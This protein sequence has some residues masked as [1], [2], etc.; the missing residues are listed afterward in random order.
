MVLGWILGV[1]NVSGVKLVAKKKLLSYS[2][3]EEPKRRVTLYLHFGELSKALNFFCSIDWKCGIFHW[4]LKALQKQRY[5]RYFGLTR[6]HW[7]L[8]L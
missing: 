6:Q 4:K 3:A 1:W 5:T 2:D 7:I 8:S